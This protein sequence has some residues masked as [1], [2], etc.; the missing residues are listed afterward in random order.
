[1]G[2]ANVRERLR[3]LFGPAGRLVLETL[4]GGGVRVEVRLPLE[5][6][7]ALRPI[8]ERDPIDDS[9]FDA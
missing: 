1:V 4:P 5:V 6:W 3:E 8:Q 2:L 9:S 7:P